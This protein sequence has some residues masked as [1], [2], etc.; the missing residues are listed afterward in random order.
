MGFGPLEPAARSR[1]RI[2][3]FGTNNVGEREI[4]LNPWACHHP[5]SA[6]PLVAPRP[7]LCAVVRIGGTGGRTPLAG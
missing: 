2:A 6:Q 4:G 1:A 7:G 3:E 5:D